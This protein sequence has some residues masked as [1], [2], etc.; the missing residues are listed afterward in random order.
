MNSP[1]LPTPGNNNFTE[2]NNDHQAR[3]QKT[4]TAATHSSDYQVSFCAQIIPKQII[5]IF[6][7]P[8]IQIKRTAYHR[9]QTSSGGRFFPL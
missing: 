5:F 9:E 3:G 7:A 8:D 2:V 1:S 4:N 6:S